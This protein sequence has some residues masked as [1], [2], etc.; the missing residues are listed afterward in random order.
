MNILV[1]DN[2]HQEN[3]EKKFGRLKENGKVIFVV[4]VM[5]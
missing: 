1:M 2:K 5:M 4:V 3:Y